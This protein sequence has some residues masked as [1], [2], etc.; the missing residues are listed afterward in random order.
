M[1]R[2]GT[3]DELRTIVAGSTQVR[4]LSSRHSFNDIADAATVVDLR[5]LP[6]SIDVDTDAGLVR[7]RG[8]VTYGTLI[9]ELKNHGVSVH[10]LA[11]LPHIS[12][13]GA[14]A[15]GTHGSGRGN[16]NLATA[17]TSV[18][19][20]LANGESVL[21]E[22]GHADFEGMVVSLGA[23]GIATEVTLEI[24]PA[25]D[26]VQHVY[27]D[28]EFDTWVEHFDEISAMGYSVSAFTS[29]TN[30]IEQ[31]WV[32]ASVADAKPVDSLFGGTPSVVDRHPIRELSAEACTEQLGVPGSWADRLPHFKL[33]FTPS[34]GDEIQSEFFIDRRELGPAV[35]ALRSLGPALS[36]AML[37]SEVRS[38]A[39][40]ELW[41]S[42]N[43]R[44][45]SV[46][47]HFTWVL[48]VAKADAAAAAV[49]NA[50]RPMG[51]RAHWGKVAPF[52]PAM[53]DTF[54]R[55]SDFLELVERHDPHGR[56]RNMWF[57][58]VFGS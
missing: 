12:V 41:M 40:D 13:A 50:L 6:A 18:E 23:F 55:A 48:D 38:I 4:G 47:F 35:D 9:P 58:R 17:V 43:H 20:L 28:L 54:D 29:W 2:P 39:A 22:R 7:T 19:Y 32:K 15:T 37:I 8:P 3:I 45:D 36:D 46:A 31:V 53:L 49:W 24:A 5:G 56:F 30:G 52:G 33:D 51:V 10:N 26:A 21:V 25:W 11:S 57:D 1:V 34:A 44:R 14:I 16:G 42:P 27:E